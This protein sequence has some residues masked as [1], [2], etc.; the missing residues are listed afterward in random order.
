M[1]V[2]VSFARPGGRVV[3]VTGPK[4]E[5]LARVRSGAVERGFLRARIH[6][7]D[8]P[9]LS[10]SIEGKIVTLE[11]SDELRARARTMAPLGEVLVY[12]EG[13]LRTEA[14]AEGYRAAAPSERI[15]IALLVDVAPLSPPIWATS[16]SLEWWISR[17]FRAA[18][19]GG[20]VAWIL[21]CI[22]G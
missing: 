20:V 11:A 9:M 3:G 13:S 16:A 18:A 4:I 2:A 15:L 5:S 8:T 7:G 14:V 22:I 21:R 1:L 6:G 12:V 19:A 10:A 17:G